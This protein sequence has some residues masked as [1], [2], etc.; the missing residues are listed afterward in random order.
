MESKKYQ[1]F[2]SS[3]YKDLINTRKKVIETILNSYHFPVGMEMF[4][5]DDAEQWEIIKETIE[6]SDYYIVIIGH[7][8]GSLSPDGEFSYT[9]RE[10]DYACNLGIPVLAFIRNRDIATLPKERETNPI[11][12][13][14]LEAFIQKSQAS[15]MCSFWSEPDELAAQVAVVL[16]KVFKRTPRI[17]WVRASNLPGKDVLNELTGLLT[18]NRKLK[19]KL[20]EYE[21]LFS[22]RTPKIEFNIIDED[23]VS[24]LYK[25]THRFTWPKWIKFD[26]IPKELKDYVTKEEI[27]QYNDNIPDENVIQ[28][29]LDNNNIVNNKDNALL[30]K[31]I[32][33][34]NGTSPANDIY[35]DVVFPDFLKVIWKD[36]MDEYR[37]IDMSSLESPVV[38]AQRRYQ[39]KGSIADKF[40]AISDRLSSF[41]RMYPPL[42]SLH[43]KATLNSYIKSINLFD[44]HRS[45][46]LDGNI[47]KIKINKLPH[48]R[49]EIIEDIYVIPI[50]KGEG[51]IKIRV[52]CN[53]MEEPLIFTKN[54]KVN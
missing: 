54:V 4:G 53:E 17:G 13:E 49:E 8:Y 44:D 46:R 12:A 34:N 41:D 43:T 7:R 26:E 23:S 38:K 31:P 22:S 14:K 6:L 1:I 16:S 5:A 28:K 32:V 30:I 36:E 37:H 27:E 39:L 47:L 9:E 25:S 45:G 52:M 33:F 11:M 35:I 2:V 50:K 48:T 10:Y 24:L 21:R 40:L 42:S 29:K 18:E 15:K 3:T 19:E 20:T 51:Y